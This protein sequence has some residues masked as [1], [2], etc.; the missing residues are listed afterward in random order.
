VKKK[1]WLEKGDRPLFPRESNPEKK[2]EK[3]GAFFMPHV[4]F[5]DI[6]TYLI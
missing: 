2:E 3:K 4:I 6:N 1:V 5:F